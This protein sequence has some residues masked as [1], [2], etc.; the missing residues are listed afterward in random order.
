MRPT[1]FYRIAAIVNL[2]FALGHTIGF[3]TFQPKAPAGQ[4]AVKA[5]AVLFDEDGT[6]ISYADFYR[7]FGLTISMVMLLIAGL[8]WWMGGIAKAT[9][10]ATVAPGAMVLAYQLGTLVL[11]ILYF[12][13]PAMIFSIAMAALYAIAVTGA[14]RA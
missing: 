2:L 13:L 11:A 10:R 1:L 7:G 12:P 14:A 3:L 8:S 4:A 6:R 5:M 9:P